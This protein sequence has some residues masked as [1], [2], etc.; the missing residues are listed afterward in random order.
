M[1]AELQS[2]LDKIQTDGV[3]KAKERAA[4][5]IAE[6]EKK[7]AD[8]IAAAKKDAAAAAEKAAADAES[9]RARSEQA[10]RQA[11]R[12]IILGIEDAVADTFERILKKE[13]ERTLSSGFLEQLVDKI[14]MAYINDSDASGGMEIRV[15]A[16]EAASLEEH[17]RAAF[18][19]AAS[20]GG[21]VV[22]ASGDVGA[23]IR[24]MLADGR[25]EHDFTAEAL[26]EK[27][28]LILRPELIKLISRK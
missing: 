27:L 19:N 20:S 28:S 24:L 21:I 1:T 4:A 12:D 18:K 5:I 15:T 8:I 6:A 17:V 7:A 10:V 2:L 11:S 9:M 3:D 13:T 22:K 14:V 26:M 23:G 25:I 16:E